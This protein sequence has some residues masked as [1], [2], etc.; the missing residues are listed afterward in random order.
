[1]INSVKGKIKNKLG[2][3]IIIDVGS[4]S[5]IITLSKRSIDLLP[6]PLNED[7]EILTY[8][9]VREDA[10]ELYGFL[11]IK[12]MD[13]FKNLISISKIGPKMAITILSDTE[14]SQLIKDI[15]F[16]N[17][18]EITKI[19]GIGKKTAQRIIL[20]LK[21]KL[22]ID[23]ISN[24]EIDQ[25]ENSDLYSDVLRSLVSLGINRTDVERVLREMKSDNEFD[26]KIEKII[27]K[28]LTRL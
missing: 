7:I 28:A 3:N 22:N 8:L 11:D 4:F 17:V 27:K 13:L 10:L 23:S 25:T 24:Q 19:S 21:D 1:L 15:K 20:E 2:N 14:P 9:N 18:S 16:N 5:L 12:E 26:D 6:N